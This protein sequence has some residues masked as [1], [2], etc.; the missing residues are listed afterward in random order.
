MQFQQLDNSFTKITFD[1]TS[2]DQSIMTSFKKSLTLE[3]PGWQYDFQIKI[4]RASKYE[5]FYQQLDANTLV[6]SSGILDLPPIRQ[7][8]DLDI[9]EP[10]DTNTQEFV[11]MLDS[12]NLAFE[13]YPY[14]IEAAI[15]A[16][17]VPR[18]LSLMCT[19]SGKS[20]TISLC[21]EYFRQK[22][23]KGVL[24][25]PNI[26]LLTQFANDI[27]SY[28]LDD[29]YKTIITFGG[30]SKQLK[31]LREQDKTL[32]PGQ[33]V[34]TTW[35]SLSKL[36]PQFFR[37][38]DYIICDE[39]HKF[40]SKCTSQLVL[41]T[42]NA[43]FKLGF[44]GTLPDSKNAK[45]TLFGLFGPP[46]TI[47]TSYELIQ[48]G[49]GTPIHITAVKLYHT[50]ESSDK[51]GIYS[52]YLDKVKQAISNESRTEVIANIAK[53]AS[54]KSQGS[55]LVLFSLL[56]HGEQLY[57]AITS[58]EPGTLQE[59]QKIGVYFMSGKTTAKDREQ[60]RNI[61]QEDMSAILVANY[62]LLSTGVNIKS[63]RYAIF[64]SPV[65]SGVTVAQSLGRGIRLSDDKEQFNVYDI[66]DELA[67]CK[68][69][70]RQFL[71]RK[72]IYQKLKFT[73]D[74]REHQLKMETN[75]YN[76]KNQRISFT[77]GDISSISDSF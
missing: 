9:Q 56:D 69:F 22:N 50:Q 37:S 58:K 45:L 29:L 76:N 51:V 11:D 53:S 25:V 63:L 6:V 47:I 27:K 35:Q 3:R 44:T 31:Q 54:A 18:K 4:G 70:H 66:V 14:Q 26:N 61:M 41:D 39:V 60:I 38:L 13:P 46:D 72:K 48:Q 75:E 10:Q 21:L 8:L 77:N 19:G 52:E 71:A 34:I 62:Q 43:Q 57:K 40:S 65:K 55:V 49:R 7:V 5:V 33:L 67:S 16:L 74:E 32:L 2:K 20:L 24:V 15:K 42:K 17:N 28:N 12:L 64:A 59:M 36:D 1:N 23:L 30:G 68:I 73:V